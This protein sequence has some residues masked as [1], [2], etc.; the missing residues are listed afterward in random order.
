[1]IFIKFKLPLKAMRAAPPEETVKEKG[2]RNRCVGSGTFSMFGQRR[3]F[4]IDT[5]ILI[6]ALG[7]GGG[8]VL[9]G[10]VGH[11]GVAGQD[12]LSEATGPRER[13]F[14]GCANDGF[15]VAQLGRKRKTRR[16]V[17]VVQEESRPSSASI[18]GWR[19]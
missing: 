19:A 6:A 16:P 7:H 2:A 11:Q 3:R 8:L 17:A 10:L 5:V 14:N 1:M 18:C 4:R 12:R 15:I 13:F 9:L